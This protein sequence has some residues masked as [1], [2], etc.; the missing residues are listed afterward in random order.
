MVQ[1]ITN[2]NP[3]RAKV[4][5]EYSGVGALK[6]DS[7]RG[8][9]LY[10]VICAAC[11]RLKNEGTEIGIDLGMVAAK[12]TEQLVEAIMDPNRAV[13]ARYVAHTITLKDGREVVGMV[14]E[15]TAN[16]L[17]VKL[18]TGT[19]VILRS[20]ITRRTSSTK[21]LMPDGLEN[22]LK[23]QDVADIIA[24]IREK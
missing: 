14:A 17:T 22:L 21:S 4:V 24:W 8:H 6:G 19:D 12:P 1:I 10:T 2:S 7:A 11:H 5:K 15:E 20:D 18:A 13:E 23:P 3:D 9:A 16:S